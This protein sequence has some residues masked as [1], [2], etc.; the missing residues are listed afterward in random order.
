MKS[1]LHEKL[2]AGKPMFPR[3]RSSIAAMAM[4]TLAACADPVQLRSGAEAVHV[5]DIANVGSCV[6]HGTVHVSV[7]NK[8]GPI[9]RREL[10]VEDELAD[11]ARNSA[12]ESGGDTIASTGPVVDGARDFNIWGLLKISFRA[13]PN[14]TDRDFLQ[15]FRFQS[16]SCTFLRFPAGI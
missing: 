8:I 11:L 6:A 15:L 13:Q 9:N 10:S 4:L 14:L 3:F 2:S 16:R 12:L 7:L 1:V 5:S